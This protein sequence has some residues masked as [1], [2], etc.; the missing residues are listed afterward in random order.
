VTDASRPELTP[1]QERTLGVL[2][3][4]GD[5]VVFD[6][7]L[8]A[9]LRAQA[10]DAFEELAARLPPE[11]PDERPV[12]VTK[13]VLGRIH[14]CERAY[15][16]PDDF[17]WTPA[18]AKGQVAHKAIE[19]A[20]H[21][22]GDPVPATL[23]DE[24]IERL[25]DDQRSLGDW[26]AGLSEADRAELRSQTT[27]LVIK[28]QESFPPLDPRWRPAM[29]SASRWPIEGRVQLS[30]RVDL[31]IGQP[32]GRESRKVI[33]DLKSG[34][35]APRH[36]EDLRFYAL[37][38]TL[39]RDVPPRLLASFYLDA[40]MAHAEEVTEGVLRA[41]LRRTLD[42]VA[43]VIELQHEGRPPTVSPGRFCRW[44]SVQADCAE[45]QEH[46]RRLDDPDVDQPW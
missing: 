13:H 24:A 19:L 36:R 46:L 21:W 40:A 9:E 44:C 6:P 42:G 30:A 18:R 23:V 28:F 8:V 5:P 10:I 4:Q 22:R 43:R 41:A 3:R 27:D 15:L 16:A 12:V 39:A 7:E 33:V 2:R 11:R 14:D 26:L 1:A 25:A 20:V 35:V 34:G 32:Q 45:G 31:A 17:S 38:E 29:E 37:V